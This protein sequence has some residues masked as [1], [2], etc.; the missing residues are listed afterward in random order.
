MS[1]KRHQSPAYQQP[2]KTNPLSQLPRQSRGAGHEPRRKGIPSRQSETSRAAASSQGPARPKTVQLYTL[3][4]FILYGPISPRFAKKNRVLSRT[5]VM[6]G[7]QTLADLH[8]AIFDA[9]DRW[10]EHFYE[11]QFGKGPMDP[12][13]PRYVL[14]DVFETEQDEERP[15]AGEVERTTL[16][17]LGLKVGRRFGYW[18]DFGDDW[19]HQINV[20]EIQPGV[21]KGRYPRV[22]K[23][24]GKSPPQYPDE[25]DL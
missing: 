21:P 18:F 24:Q 20:E 10:E 13:G 23:R 14:S 22:I 19:W 17:S 1:Q 6:H 8:E 7:D 5:I 25:E 16:D 4:V 15:P 2:N 3:Q 11:F 9:F 12:Q